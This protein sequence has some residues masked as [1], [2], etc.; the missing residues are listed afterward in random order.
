MSLGRRTKSSGLCDVP[1][2]YVVTA[3]QRDTPGLLAT[4]DEVGT[5]R[6]W[7]QLVARCD[8]RGLPAGRASW[9]A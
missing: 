5:L 3:D 7:F 6:D 1:G 4:K 2:D 9:S 8:V